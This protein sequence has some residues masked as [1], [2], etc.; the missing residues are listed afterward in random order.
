[1][2]CNRTFLNLTLG[3]AENGEISE[4]HL[5]NALETLFKLIQS[6][7]ARQLSLRF[8][9]DWSVAFPIA[10]LLPS[11]LERVRRFMQHR[12]LPAFPQFQM[13]TGN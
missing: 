10:E 4:R 5:V 6:D 3:A 11:R 12:L 7:K 9:V 8:G 1:M 2:L 13:K